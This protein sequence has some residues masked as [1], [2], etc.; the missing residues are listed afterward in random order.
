[1]ENEKNDPRLL[2]YKTQ[3]EQINTRLESE[4]SE[5]KNQAVSIAS[6]QEKINS[7]ETV[8][9]KAELQYSTSLQEVK[10]RYE[11][12]I[13]Q[14][15]D[16]ARENE[17]NLNL[18]FEERLSEQKLTL[19]KTKQ[20]F[21]DQF[22]VL[23][24]RI[25]ED[26]SEKF[27]KQNKENIEGFLTPLREKI[28]EFEQKVD[29]TY[30]SE[31]R[32]RISLKKEIEQLVGLNQKL[33]EDAVNLTSALKG[34][35]KVQGDWG[36]IQLELILEKAGLHKEIHYSTQ[37]SFK[38]E[39]GLQ[40]RPDLIINLPE[41][42]NLIIDS[43]VSLVAYEKYVNSKES[44]DKER[45]LKDHIL[46][47][48]NHIKS[49]S[50][51]KYQEI[52]EINSPDYVLMF[53]PIEPALNLVI[54]ADQKIFLDALEK[55]VVLVSSSTLLATMKTVSFIWKQ[56]DQKKNVLEIARQGAA[57][58]DKFVGFTEDLVKIGKE[59][60]SAKNNYDQAM[61]K[62]TDGKGNL[63]RRTEEL[64]KLG[65]KTQKELNPKLV[66]RSNELDTDE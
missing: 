21:T 40:K 17:R 2:E 45:A 6:F 56:E 13:K 49:L 54:S 1:M 33:S 48:K 31:T 10:E 38:D 29:R 4:I 58:Y 66:E 16:F 61:N 20:E 8:L 35:S 59:L 37:S 62:L 65:L 44:A 22:Q 12:K 23:A 7:L 19:E 27:T 3:L 41:G 32:E 5:N 50:D 24:N 11:D 63:I 53:V 30:E 51:K 9:S 46:S 34:D 26:K 43:K 55:N 39:E 42:K 14:I 57:L 52:Y 47:V 25:F 60:N 64:K 18:H 15:Q 36:E 28:K